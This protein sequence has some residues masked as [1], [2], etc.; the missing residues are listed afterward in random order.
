[1]MATVPIGEALAGIQ[2]A[3]LPASHIAVEA[4]ILIR[5]MDEEGKP[6][7]IYRVT[8][9][10]AIPDAIG[11]IVTCGDLLRDRFLKGWSL[12]EGDEV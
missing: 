12:D 7:W 2:I 1:M 6:C 5:A 4:V 3:P 8:N 10:M 11:G 9:G